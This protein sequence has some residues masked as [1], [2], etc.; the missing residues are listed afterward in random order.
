[1]ELPYIPG[2]FGTSIGLPLHIHCFPPCINTGNTI[3][4]PKNLII[5][6]FEKITSL[7]L[8]LFLY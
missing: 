5:L 6:I 1:M 7:H 2:G 3:I 8:I 4:F